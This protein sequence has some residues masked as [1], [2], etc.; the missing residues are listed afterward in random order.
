MVVH[1]GRIRLTYFSVKSEILYYFYFK[2]ITILLTFNYFELLPTGR[3]IWLG[4]GTRRI[5][6]N[7]TKLIP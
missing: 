2:L 4:K 6:K 1:S 5:P 3:H 7:V